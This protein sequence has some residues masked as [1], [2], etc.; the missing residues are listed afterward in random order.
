MPHDPKPLP[1]DLVPLMH[2]HS[3]AEA[4]V[5]ASLLQA[6]HIPVYVDGLQLMDDFA[7]SQAVLGLKSDICVHPSDLQRAELL[8]DE[9]RESGRELKR[10]DADSGH[11]GQA[12]A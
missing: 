9:A 5:V 6:A 1:E 4:A 7:M 11:A 3:R 12:G 2:A 10:R 8:L